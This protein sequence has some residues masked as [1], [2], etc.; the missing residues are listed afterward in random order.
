MSVRFYGW[1]FEPLSIFPNAVAVKQVDG[2][3]HKVVNYFN[4]I[5][6]IGFAILVYAAHRRIR[7]FR[8]N[9][10]DPVVEDFT[11]RFEAAGDA[12]EGRRGRFRRWLDDWK[13]T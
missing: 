11:D 12:M 5:F 6:L 13:Q 2:P 3:D 7:R 4:I 1:R 10:I 9:R 8:E